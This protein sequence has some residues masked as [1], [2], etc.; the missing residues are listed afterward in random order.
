MSAAF[1][2]TEFKT[3]VGAN[4]GAEKLIDFTGEYREL[5]ELLK[6]YA[7][8]SLSPWT[9]IEFIGNDEEPITIGSSNTSGKYRETGVVSIHTVGIAKLGGSATILS[10]AESLRSKLRGIRLGPIHVTS[11]TPPNFQ[12]GATLQFEGGWM[13]ATFL[14]AYEYDYDF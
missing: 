6:A 11:V 8:P 3:F 7:V 4:I 9:G 14:V 1:V 12:D 2:R 10:R 5:N 13:S